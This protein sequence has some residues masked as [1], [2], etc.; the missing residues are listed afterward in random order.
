VPLK[1]SW[2]RNIAACL[3][4]TLAWGAGHSASAAAP[5][6]LPVSQVRDGMR[7]YG[8]TV[9]SGARIDTFQVEV[10]AVLRGY[11]V[12]NDAIIARLSG[13]P[14]AQAGVAE[15]MSGSPV[16]IGGKLVGAVAWTSTFTKEPLA[17]I[18]P[19]EYMAE[20]PKR[21]MGEPAPDRYT[22]LPPRPGTQT[23]FDHWWRGESA[24]R[25][26][27]MSAAEAPQLP[28]AWASNPALAQAA[29]T[30]MVPVKTPLAVSGINPRAVGLLQELV[31][32][33]N[34]S[35]V[36][37]GAV[38]AQAMD[39]VTL[40]PGSSLG[41]TLARG[42]ISMVAVGTVTWRD[43]DT[44]LGFGHPMFF[45]GQIDLPMSLAYVHFLW[46]SQY[47]SYK[48]ASGGPVV[49]SLRQ[50]RRFGVAGVIGGP[51]QMLPVEV[52]IGGG[53]RP[54]HVSFEVTRDRDFGP[55]LV[56][57]GL[58]TSLYDLEMLSGPATL[59]FEEVIDIDGHAAIRRK[60][61]YTDYGGLAAAAM[62]AGVPLEQL[63]RNPFESV[64]ISRVSFNV[65]FRE[66]INAAFVTGLEIP[67]R[68]VRPGEPLIVKTRMKT[69]LGREFEVTTELPVAPSTPEGVYTLRVGDA[70]SAE[71]WQVNRAP[72]RFM[73]ENLDQLIDVLNF[74]ERNDR[75]TLEVVN[76]DLGMTIDDQVLPS[77][78]HTTFEMLR[79]A[80]PSGRV[81]PVFGT[82]IA[83][84]QVPMGLY[85]VGSQ[86]IPVAVYDLARP[87]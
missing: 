48:V 62:D 57:L 63:A 42:D 8:L 58:L 9:F 3:G 71:Q 28:S 67:R 30:S 37:G 46:P 6:V 27:A 84:E 31:E 40:Q 49:G 68:V 76:S 4:V 65:Q 11:G 32:P 15:G 10:L 87:R 14:L 23:D 69:Y 41:V 86:E 55:K 22:L 70:A 50:D 72:G 81:G 34:M 66:E 13:G 64:R 36:Q 45:K 54:H 17:G 5:D 19:F 59:E 44:I 2:F 47:I 29:G 78:P 25:A 43:G 79:S 56:A 12:Q 21:P 26:G 24:A 1:A 33:Y 20:I 38:S 16:F 83:R 73:P 39:G 75:L 82:P 61:L 18:T 60:N 52:N 7:G 51:Q 35:V 85:V 80:V 77:L 74:Q 53:P